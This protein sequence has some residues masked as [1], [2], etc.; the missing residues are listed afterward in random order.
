LFESKIAKAQLTTIKGAGHMA[1]LEKTAE[2][3]SEVKGFLG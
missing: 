3:V 1:P 2:F